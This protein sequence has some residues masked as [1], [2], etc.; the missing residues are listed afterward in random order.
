[1]S[2]EI[3]V[4]NATEADLDGVMD[5]ERSW[6]ETMQAPSEKFV[7]R[8]KYFPEGF[9]V[10]L[11]SGRILGVS[12]SKIFHYDKNNPPKTWD[13]ASDE[14]WITK[15]DP[16]G[17]ALYV[18]SVGVHEKFQG[19]GI[20]QR[21]VEAQKKLVKVLGLDCLVLGARCPEY[22]NP[23]FNNIFPEEYVRLKRSDGQPRD[24]EIRFYSRYELQVVCPMPEYMGKGNDPESRD[25]GVIMVWNNPEKK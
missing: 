20:G 8:M 16:K 21:L 6:P 22:S 18:V 9:Y 3:T 10:A 14:G 7:S 19:K 12:T 2:D 5:V 1:M 11:V 25:F 15:H 4:R 17:N 13:E 24:K 23:E